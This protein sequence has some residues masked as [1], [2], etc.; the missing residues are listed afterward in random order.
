MGLTVVKARLRLGSILLLASCLVACEKSSVPVPPSTGADSDGHGPATEIT[1]GLNA[2][3]GQSMANWPG[4]EN[5][6][7][8]RGLVAV[9]DALTIAGLEGTVAWDRPSYDFIAGVAPDTVNPSL[10]RQERLNNQT[11]LFRVSDG[12]YQLRGFDLANMTLISGERGWIVVDP[13]TTVE[14]ARAALA[15]AREHLDQRPV[16]AVIFTH[17]HVDHF[18]GVYGVVTPEAV[19]KGDVQ[20]VAPQHFMAEATSEL[21]LAGQVMSRRADYMYGRRLSRSPRGH[22]GS[23]LGKQPALGSVTIAE[24]SLTVVEPLENHTIDGVS[25]VFQIVSGSEAPAEFV[26]YLPEQHALCGAE[27]VSRNLHNLY[28]LRG[29][30]VRDALAWSGFIESSRQAFPDAEVL[31]NSHHWPVWGAE[32][33]QDFLKGHRDV[34]KYIH[35]QTLRLAGQ[36]MTPAEIADAI[37]LPRSLTEAF[38]IR[39]YYGTVRH[40][41]RAVYQFYFGWYDANPAHLNPL[42]PVEAGSRYVDLLG[43]AAGVLSAAEAAY[44][45]GDYRWVAELLNHLVFAEPENIAARALLADTYDQLGYQAES[46]PWRDVY[47]SGAYELRQGAPEKALPTGYIRSIL[48]ETPVE[49]V[50]ELLATMINGPEAAD[51]ELILNF[52]LTDLNRN[53]VLRLENAVLHHREQ[54]LA[55]DASVTIN[56]GHDFLLDIMV[57]DVDV[58]TLLTTD[59]LD[60]DGSRVD[61]VKFLS[62]LQSTDGAFAIVTP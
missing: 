21:V 62:L 57:G 51:S 38:P 12:I 58:S 34:Y 27:L 47:L 48:R 9:P 44:S 13:L 23:G 25:F 52:N 56:I 19:A 61:L 33:I 31:F 3:L 10:W 40:N 42:P 53:F 41:S 6:D 4:A 20:I 7:A 8:Q 18:G 2:E 59:D 22:V 39:G 35:D 54:P 17:S 24:P 32:N 49:R 37:V 55:D 36:G 28:T 43:G 15:F 5:S 46:G 16:T 30:K 14:T 50:M 29:A 60:I 1:A 45:E 11:G 26:F